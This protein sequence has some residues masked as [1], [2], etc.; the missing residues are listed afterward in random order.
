MCFCHQLFSTV[1][2]GLQRLAQHTW[3][4]HCKFE[5]QK[6]TYKAKL[7]DQ[8]GVSS[9]HPG[10]AGMNDKEKY[11]PLEGVTDFYKKHTEKIGLV[12]R[13]DL[14]SSCLRFLLSPEIFYSV[15]TNSFFA[16]FTHR[17]TFTFHIQHGDAC[18]VLQF[19]S[20]RPSPRNVASVHKVE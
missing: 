19:G 9:K 20:P 17:G 6:A 11:F 12:A 3:Y 2:I 14:H 13:P 15:I 16:W 4:C 5:V 7:R 10:V 1:S 18:V 8:A